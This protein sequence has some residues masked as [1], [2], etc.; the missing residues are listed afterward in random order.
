MLQRILFLL[1]YG[2][3]A[4]IYSINLDILNPEISHAV[5]IGKKRTVSTQ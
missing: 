3:V 4:S 2:P 1:H 5:V